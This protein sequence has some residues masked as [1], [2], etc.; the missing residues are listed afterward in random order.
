MNSLQF[1]C[2]ETTRENY[3]QRFGIFKNTKCKSIKD[4]SYEFY[5]VWNEKREHFF[6][7]I[8][9]SFSHFFWNRTGMMTT[10]APG[11]DS[12]LQTKPAI[13][14]YK[15]ITKLMTNSYFCNIYYKLLWI[16]SSIIWLPDK[17]GNSE[18][19]VKDVFIYLMAFDCWGFHGICLKWTK[20]S[21]RISFTI[22]M[23]YWGTM[24]LHLS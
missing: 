23:L 15:N 13:D 12:L 4:L 19:E 16:Y 18:D 1:E 8:V 5:S 20:Q 17:G 2:D 6:I 9:F 11:K 21:K 22:E 14:I 7:F 3:C 24:G 10:G